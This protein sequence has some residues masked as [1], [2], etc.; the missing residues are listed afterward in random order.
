MAQAE[1]M[2]NIYAKIGFDKLDEAQRAN[3][4]STLGLPTGTLND[5]VSSQPKETNV[6]YE[7]R[8][9]ER[10]GFIQFKKDKRTGE[11]L[12][13][14]IITPSRGLEGTGGEVDLGLPITKVDI[15]S[16]LDQSSFNT[17]LLEQEKKANMSFSP[18]K[19]K[20]LKEEWEKM[21]VATNPESVDLSKFAPTVQLII[22]GVVKASSLTM[23]E[24]N[25]YASQI[26]QAAN[27]GLIPVETTA[28]Q[29]D[30]FNK[31][32]KEFENSPLVKAKDRS[33]V[34][35]S[36]IESIRKNP[37]DGAT[38]LQM[39][40]SYVQ[41]LDTYQSAVREGEL[42]LVNSIDSRIGQLQGSIQKIQNGQIVR[43]EV[44]KQIADA[45]EQ[46]YKTINSGAEDKEKSFSSR[47]K[48]LR[49]D[50]QWSLYQ[51]GYNPNY[52]TPADKALWDNNV[53]DTNESLLSK[54]GVEK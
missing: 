27:L 46:L 33:V 22:K 14:K 28:E 1:T 19:R 21:Q 36:S 12:D 32:A 8:S 47:A 11:I 2:Y 34:L 7:L 17:Y 13:Q 53:S 31:L 5:I 51:T 20:E 9:T 41:A 42:S 10:G 26:N 16:G 35:K 6:E 39:V 38:Q 54:Y 29:L 44:A 18:E 48:V 52:K 4:E 3:L 49:I 25:K 45:A 40:Y 50:D 43:P 23:S 15:S 37:K 24:R 30:T